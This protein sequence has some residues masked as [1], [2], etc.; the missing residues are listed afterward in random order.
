MERDAGM[1]HWSAFGNIGMNSPTLFI[2]FWR[3]MGL[4]FILL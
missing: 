1:Q 4:G 3:G 2:A